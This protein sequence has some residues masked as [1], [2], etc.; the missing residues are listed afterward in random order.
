MPPLVHVGTLFFFFLLST[1]PSHCLLSSPSS[2][3]FFL[4]FLCLLS[5]SLSVSVWC[6]VWCCVCCVCVCVC[7]ER[8]GPGRFQRATHTTAT[9]TATHHRHHIDIHTQHN[10]TRNITRRQR[11]RNKIKGKDR[12]VSKLRSFVTWFCSFPLPQMVTCGWQ[13]AAAHVYLFCQIVSAAAVACG[14]QFAGF[15]IQAYMM[16]SAGVFV[17]GF[18]LSIVESYLKSAAALQSV[19]VQI[20]AAARLVSAAV[21]VA[22]FGIIT[23]VFALVIAFLLALVESSVKSAAALQFVDVQIVAAARLVSAVAI[24]ASIGIFTLVDHFFAFGIFWVPGSLQNCVWK[25]PLSDPAGIVCS[26]KPLFLDCKGGS[27]L[28][29]WSRGSCA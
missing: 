13:S 14:A 18:H 7:W 6:C 4:L 20:V 22:S 10:T 23:L 9:A 21:S 24:F 28:C 29:I 12:S 1:H 8:R 25:L 26:C 16:V 3:V 15:G 5:R 27:H 19:E 11:Q 2:F 17:L